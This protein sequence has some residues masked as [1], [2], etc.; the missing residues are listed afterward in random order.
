[1]IFLDF[2]GNSVKRS[3]RNARFD[4]SLIIKIISWI[5]ILYVF[6]VLIYA[7]YDFKRV[8]QTIDPALNPVTLVN[9][10][11]LH[12]CAAAVILQFFST[13]GFLKEI[14]TYLHLPVKRNKILSYLLI[15]APANYVMAGLLLFF[16]PYSLRVILPYYSPQQYV[17]YISGLLI[18][19]LSAAYLSLFFRNLFEISLFYIILPFC[20]MI[21]FYILSLLANISFTTISDFVFA[22][23]INQNIYFMVFLIVCLTGLITINFLLLKNIIYR[24]Y[25]DQKYQSDYPFLMNPYSFNSDII[26]YALMEIKLIIRNKRLRGFFLFA[27]IPLVLFYAILPENDEGLYFTFGIYIMISGMF[28]Y[29]FLQYLFSWE[30]SFFDFL[31]SKK[32][33]MLKYLKSKY[34]IYSILSLIVFMV[35]LPLLSQSKTEI[36]MFLSA[37]LYNSGFGYFLFFF[38]AS[39]NRSRIDLE[40]NVFFNYQ[41]LNKVQFLALTIIILLPLL[42]I[43]AL[44]FIMTLTQS[45]LIMNFLSLVPLLYQNRVWQIIINQLLKRKYINLQGYRT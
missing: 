33:D 2:I 34:W 31:M 36:H 38:L 19:F 26:N 22:Q 42:L 10:A 32:F 29:I 8:I 24:I 6:V 45:L 5:S 20:L 4:L 28:G 37:L 15:T 41:G 27:L 35:F 14:I 17:F 13:K 18:I 30:S 43:F 44:S 25:Q 11:L 1:M 12:L 9:H 39:Y 7:G 40:G 3:V 16:I 23:L 21:G